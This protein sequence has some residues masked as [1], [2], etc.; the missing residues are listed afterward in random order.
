M[1]IND[2]GQEVG[3]PLASWSPRPIPPREPLVGRHCRLEPLE[4]AHCD[5]LFAAY[6]AAPDGRDWTYL[7]SERLDDREMFRRALEAQV[8]SRD[9][10]HFAIAV[11]GVAKG[12]SA[13]MRIDPDIGVIEIGHVIF[14]R[15]LQRTAAGTEAIVLLIRRAFDL[16]Y[17]R[18]EWKCDSLN[19]PSRHAA[20]RYGFVFEGIFRQAIVTKGRSRD[21]AWFAMTDAD[22]PAHR[23]ALDRWLAPGNVDE[24]G[25]QVRSLA[26]VRRQTGLG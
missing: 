18:V 14:S 15:A 17:R 21:T 11:G 5:A 23:E 12:S 7:P 16:G 20:L 6:Q 25:L 8:A 24:G 26:E 2:F 19:A 4:P 9:P 3:A 22:W 1:P 13:L 10:L